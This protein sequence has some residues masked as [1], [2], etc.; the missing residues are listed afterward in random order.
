MVCAMKV[1]DGTP[2][3]SFTRGRPSSVAVIGTASICARLAPTASEVVGVA[4]LTTLEYDRE[5]PE[6]WI[7]A[8]K[9]ARVI[10]QTKMRWVERDRGEVDAV[11]P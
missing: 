8:P 3:A 10:A 2:I 4:F 7:I 6:D 1:A 9:R 5:G 11:M